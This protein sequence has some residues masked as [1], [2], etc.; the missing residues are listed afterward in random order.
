[1][2]FIL[3]AQDAEM[4]K[5]ETILRASGHVV[6]HAIRHGR[7]VP[8]KFAYEAERPSGAVKWESQIVWV[9]C[10][11]PGK[12]KSHHV[13]VD[14]HRHGDFGYGKG[15]EEFYEASSIG[16]VCNLIG[17]EPTEDILYTA[18]ADHCLGAAYA[19][20]CPNIDPERMRD[21]RANTHA[22]V[23]QMTVEQFHQ[24]LD[25]TIESL[26][27]CSM[28]NIGGHEFIDA[29]DT[30]HEWV[31]DASAILGRSVMYAYF[32]RRVRRNKV[33]V[34][35]GSPEALAAWMEWAKTRPYLEDIYGDPVRGFA[36]GYLVG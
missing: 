26:K 15:P 4:Q 8:S 7:R 5:I 25:N 31:S 17:Y 27:K 14:H 2:Q 28:L 16:Q 22:A 30:Q 36:G 18:A 23:R 34:L 33:G 12:R 29:M 24:G 13:S 3:G 11:I 9:E 20:L 35:N 21:W 19:G 6:R 1:M 32:D 10:A